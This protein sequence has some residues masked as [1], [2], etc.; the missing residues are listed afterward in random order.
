MEDFMNHLPVTTTPACAAG[1]ARLPGLFAG[2][3]VLAG[4]V[5]WASHR[6][7]PPVVTFIAHDYGYEGPETIPTGLTTV[8]LVNRGREL[9]H[10]QLIRLSGG[11]TLDEFVKGASAGEGP[12][13]SWATP[14]GGPNAV[15]PGDTVDAIQQLEPGS[16]VM[17]CFIPGPDG[18]PHFTKG[19]VRG[20]QVTGHARQAVEPAADLTVKLSDYA[21]QPSGELTPG[22]RTIRVENIGPQMHELVLVRLEAGKSLHDL[23]DWAKGGFETVPPVHFVG[24][25]V[26]LA[27]G[28][29]ALFTADITPGD[30]GFLC[31]LPDAKDGAPHLAHGMMMQFRVRGAA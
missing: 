17:L 9:H 28:R 25:I 12:L 1:L 14:E 15:E 23:A 5:G 7:T 16:Y 21:F 13:P 27:P 24:G 26:G 29:H 31:F 11:H 3:I 30:Y 22:R 6:T 8:R 18:R 10:V 19:M 4:V 2:L 20:L